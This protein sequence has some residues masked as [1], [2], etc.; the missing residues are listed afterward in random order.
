MKKG[1]NRLWNWLKTRWKWYVLGY[2]HCEH[3]PY[4]WVESG[5]EDCDC[6]CYIKGDIQDT[7]RLLPPFRFLIGWPR[8]RQWEY[9]NDHAWDG[10][11]EHYEKQLERQEVFAESAV[12][13]LNQI[14]LWQRDP[15]GKPFPI[16][17]EEL[18][19]I[20]AMG[21][22][23]FYEAFIHYEE[24]AHPAKIVPLKQ[25]WKELIKLTWKHLVY[26][27]IAPY[28]PRKRRK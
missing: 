4:C 16:C 19:E 18:L 7:C 27:E 28:L 22:G 26:D 15:E 11:G 2:Y 10:I 20:Y 23:P 12:I 1:I 14:E 5:Y 24:K 17:K 3:C 25:R 13:L 21:S 6:G 9:M 8:M